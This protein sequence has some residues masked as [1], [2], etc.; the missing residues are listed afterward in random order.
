MILEIILLLVGLAVLVKGAN[1]LIDHSAHLA[2]R[3]GVS[4]LIIGLT[5][6]AFG[7]SLPEFIVSVF[8]AIKG[9]S[10]IAIAN[11][12]G[13]NI[14]NIG[15]IL[16]IS[17]IVQV[18]PIQLSTLIYE[19]PF[20]LV[21]ALLLLI[22]S[23][24]QNLFQQAGYSLG[25]IDGII[26]LAVFGLFLTYILVNAKRQRDD[27]GQKQFEEK[28]SEKDKL[29]KDLLLITIGLAALIG[30]GKLV[31]DNAV[32]IALSAGISEAFIGATIIAVGTSLPELVASIVAAV[33]KQ[34]DI[35]VGNVVGSNIFNI[36]MVLGISSLIAPLN[37]NA[38]ILFFDM[39]VMIIVSLL[40]LLFV[41]TGKKITRSEGI[42][43]VLVYLAYVAYLI[44][45]L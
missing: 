16:G 14:V 45:H 44:S 4:P 33:K 39:I 24:N 2:R 30:G 27:A 36:L 42:I 35:A 21:S 9:S 18:L 31:V 34:P 17:A 26:L 19:M 5:V 37:V 22:L 13:S 6:V 43:M 10:D 40:L 29:W 7:T 15:L 3:L 20:V 8:A 23:N 32:K 25:R 28:Y 38:S 11:V 12:V 41:T 1:F